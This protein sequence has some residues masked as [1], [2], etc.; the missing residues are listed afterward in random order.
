MKIFAKLTL[1]G[2]VTV[3]A[4]TPTLAA[5]QRS[6]GGGMNR[7]AGMNI[8][9]NQVRAAANAS[10]NRGGYNNRPGQRPNVVVVNNNRRPGGYGNG[11][12]GGRPGGYGNGYNNGYN[13][14]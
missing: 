6:Y 14:G 2:A 5:P 7:P 13:N 11:Y 8:N 9:S 4:L 1:F 10:I 3:M 12:A